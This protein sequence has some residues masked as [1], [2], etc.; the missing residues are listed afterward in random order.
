M[1]PTEPEMTSPSASD[2]GGPVEKKQK[3]TTPNDG[4]N[5]SVDNNNQ[6]YPENDD[7]I[8]K[9]QTW[10]NPDGSKEDIIEG[11]FLIYYVTHLM[12][13]FFKGRNSFTK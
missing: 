6:K 9:S 5:G 1:A 3:T 7:E 12:N 8:W 2:D 13:N 11:K 10:T 4:E